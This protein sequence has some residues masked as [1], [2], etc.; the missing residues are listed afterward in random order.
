MTANT[1]LNPYVMSIGPY[2]KLVNHYY[3][4]TLVRIIVKQFAQ[5]KYTFLQLYFIA[6]SLVLDFLM[7]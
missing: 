3:H 1:G 7:S 5:I 4:Y 6:M 2:L